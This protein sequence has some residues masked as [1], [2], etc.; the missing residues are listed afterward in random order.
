MIGVGS[1]L[2]GFAVRWNGTDSPANGVREKR[3]RGAYGSGIRA[4]S[5]RDYRQALYLTTRHKGEQS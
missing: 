2:T 5:E 1:C 3:S 4:L